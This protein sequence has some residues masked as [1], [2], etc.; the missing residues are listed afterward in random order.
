M[1][2]PDSQKYSFDYTSYKAELISIFQEIAQ[3][4]ELS[5]DKFRK[6]L[7]KYP[8]DGNKVFSKNDLIAGYEALSKVGNESL[9]EAEKILHK[10]QMKPRRTQSGVTTVTVLTK[11]F[12]CPGRCIFCPTDIRMPKSYLSDEPGAQ[13]AE[14][15]NF[16]PYLQVSS[17]LK[18]YKNIGHPTSKI[19][20]IILGGTWSFYPEGYQIWFVKRC[21]EAINDFGDGITNEETDQRSESTWDELFAQ[22]KRNEKNTCR[23]VG[24][25]VETRPD[26]ISK[27]EV[28]RIRKLGCTKVQIGIQS[29]NDD[30]L[31]KN[32]RGHNTDATKKAFE[33][34]R[35][36]GFKIH[37]HWMAN[38]YGSDVEKDILDFKK[39]FLD[40][41]FRPDELK[42]YPCSLIA[43]AELMDYY[44]KGLWK[45]YTHE[46]LLKVV[47][48]CIKNTPAY[49]RLTR[50]VRDIPSGDIIVGNKYTNFRQWAEDEIKKQNC[51]IMDIRAREIKGRKVTLDD[52]KLDIIQ[53]DSTIS[54]EYFLQYVTDDYKIA[55]FLRLSLPNF[56][57]DKKHPFMDELDNC[58]MIREIHVYGSAVN[59]G[60]KTVGKAQHLGLGTKL[61]EKAKEIAKENNYPKLA[62]ISAI[63]TR[64]Y[65]KKLGF[66]ID[67]K[68]QLTNFSD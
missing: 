44:K 50:V 8:K 1:N 54:K 38:L 63:G 22:H 7:S 13:R 51:E 12:P 61:I 24:L 17:R 32:H 60:D 9:P 37:A 67:K 29:L 39:I 2:K 5:W 28:I 11:P 64:E 45:P 19:E 34:L 6:I 40:P 18:A 65:Y 48:E 27:N 3:I 53:Y 4:D 35:W 42:I 31:E 49:C 16:D 56:S 33:L 59:V 41:A 10:I 52:L 30:V 21:F 36:G 14:R 55:G 20:L 57:T 23:N 46:E 25:V 26:H 15:N 68:Y 47:T 62:V 66:E 43:S 58:A